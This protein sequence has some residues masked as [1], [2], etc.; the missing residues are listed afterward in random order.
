MINKISIY[1]KYVKRIKMDEEGTLILTN[2]T[3]ITND[4][5]DKIKKIVI[6]KSLQGIVFSNIFEN[7]NKW[8]KDLINLEEIDFSNY[9]FDKMI[10][11]SFENCKK[12][13][14]IELPSTIKILK[15]C[16]FGN[17]EKLESVILHGV[18]EIGIWVFNGCISLKYL[19][20]SDKI[21]Q[22]DESAFERIPKEQEITI[23]CPDRFYNYF[24]ERFP[25]SNINE[26]EFVLK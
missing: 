26:N 20:I 14:S 2:E 23:I 19:F 9:T 1:N 24:K 21:K 15:W 18:E 22:I 17:C 4:M 5:L 12:I 11:L 7:N 8:I 13:K 16:C 10:N 6:D 25:N 3:K